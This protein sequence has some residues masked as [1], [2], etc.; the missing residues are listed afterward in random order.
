MTL[1][2]SPRPP[3]GATVH[4]QPGLYRLTL[5]TLIRPGGRLVQDEDVEVSSSPCVLC[6]RGGTTAPPGGL[7]NEPQRLSCFRA[8]V[9]IVGR[10][11][12]KTEW[13]GPQRPPTGSFILSQMS[14]LSSHGGLSSGPRLFL[15]QYRRGTKAVRRQS[16]AVWPACHR[17]ASSTEWVLRGRLL[18]GQ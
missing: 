4:Q 12:L 6:L 8:D 17:G 14:E 18:I 11:G 5:L 1:P 2:P 10:V 13:A 9:N 7:T 15:P 3:H 16:D